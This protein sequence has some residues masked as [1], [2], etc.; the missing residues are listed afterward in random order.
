MNAN[1]V[2]STPVDRTILFIEGVADD[3]LVRVQ[4]PKPNSSDKNLKFFSTGSL[5]HSVHIALPR[6]TNQ[7]MLMVGGSEQQFNV[8]IPLAIV[9]CIVDPDSSTQAL[10]KASKLIARIQQLAKQPVPVINPVISIR[11]TCRDLIYDAFHKLPGVVVPRTIRITP[12]SVVDVVKQIDKSGIALPFL[13]RPA[14]KHG[15]FGLQQIEDFSAK[16]KKKLER[17]AYDGGHFYVTE[18]VDFKHADGLYRKSPYDIVDGHATVSDE[19]GWGIEIHP[20]WLSKAQ[21]QISA[22]EGR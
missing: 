8:R 21:Y 11:K 5:Q 20:D 22:L 15:G 16:E 3:G 13:I 19:P 6:T 4:A 1:V 18:W 14:G 17:Y 10:V 12:N 2:E 7:T 9:N